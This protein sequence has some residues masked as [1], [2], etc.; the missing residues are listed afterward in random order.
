MAYD[1]GQLL[2]GRL[3]YAEPVSALDDVRFDRILNGFAAHYEVQR[4]GVAGFQFS[5]GEGYLRA[6]RFDAFSLADGGHVE[7]LRNSVAEMDLP[8]GN[9]VQ[10][11]PRWHGIRFTLTIRVVLLYWLFAMAALWLWLGGD[12]MLWL[13]LYIVALVGTVVMIRKSLRKKMDEW[14]AKESWN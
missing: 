11:M 12:W 13:V 2:I 4:D 9:V 10:M 7:R 8:D 3:V 1:I 5:R 14:L 6:G